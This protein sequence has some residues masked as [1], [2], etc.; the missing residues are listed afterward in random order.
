[1]ILQNA[2]IP[3]SVTRCFLIRRWITMGRSSLST[4]FVMWG[5]SGPSKVDLGRQNR[6]GIDC[7]APHAT[8]TAGLETRVRFYGSWARNLPPIRTAAE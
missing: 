2:L 3:S 6:R 5:R 4:S 8:T 7:D 1:M